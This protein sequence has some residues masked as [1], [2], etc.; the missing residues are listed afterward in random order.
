MLPADEAP[1]A[2]REPGKKEKTPFTRDERRAVL[3]LVGVC[4]LVTFFWA[5]YDQQ[6]NTLVLW[7]ED[8]TDRSI[9]LYLWKGEIPSAWFLALNPLMIFLFTPALVRLW[10]WQAARG[11]EPFTISKMTFAC[12]CVAAANLVMAAG[13]F[14]AGGGKASPLWLVGYFALITIGELYLSP[15]GLSLMSKSAPARIRS[16]MMGL[17][18]ATTF[19]A[20]ILAGY[21]GG[22]WSSMAKADFFM[23]IAAIAALGGVLIGASSRRLRSLLERP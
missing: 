15:I 12:V 19:P 20:D 7:A 11:T 13:A 23:L 16:M 9:D 6:G 5:A 22:F 3:A 1:R 4:A 14:V 21:V 2:T 17:W 18:F 10:T 8:F